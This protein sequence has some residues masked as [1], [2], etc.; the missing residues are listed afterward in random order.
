LFPQKFKVNQS[1]VCVAVM[2]R[3]FESYIVFVK[4]GVLILFNL[5]KIDSIH[6]AIT[7][8]INCFLIK[9]AACVREEGI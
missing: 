4:I 6:T 3:I 8:A 1:A 9:I 7:I 5:T 2:P